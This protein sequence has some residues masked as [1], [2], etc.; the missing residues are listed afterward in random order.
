MEYVRRYSLLF[1]L[2]FFVSQSGLAVTQKTAKKQSATYS[3][4]TF[5]KDASVLDAKRDFG[6]KGDG[7]ADDT[8]AL[9]RGID[10]SC[11]VER[12]TSAVFYIPK[13]I[14]RVSHTLVVN[15]PTGPWIY[16]ESRDGV[17]IRL[18]DGVK[19]CNS[20]IRTHPR[21]TGPTSADWFFR[22]LH[23]FTVDV[24]KNPETDGIRWCSTNTGIIRN[25]RV[26]GHG[27]IGINNGFIDQS[28][29]NLIQDVI[30]EGFETGIQEAWNW[31]ATL[32]RI[33]IRNCRKQGV[34]VNAATVAIEDLVVE[35]TP[36]GLFC[37]YPNDWTWWGGVVA[38][39]GGRFSGG[40]PKGPAIHNRSILYAR[41]VKSEGV[42]MTIQSETPGGNS[43]GL[44]VSEY[45]SHDTKKLFDV[46]PDSTYLPIKREPLMIWETNPNN[47]V[48]ANDFG[49]TS[50]DSKDDTA[51]IQKAIDTAAKS[52]KTTVYL[53]GVSG[54]GWYNVD[55]EVLIHG[56]VR[57]VIGLGFGRML[58]SEK[59][60]FVITDKSAPIIKFQNLYAF[61]GSRV[62]VENRSA[63][64]TL[65]VES[66]DLKII[67]TG[68]GD[69]FATDCSSIIEITK[70]G[71][72]FWA[73]Q[74]NPEG[75]S[76]IG[77]VQNAGA[78]AWILGMKCEGKGVRALTSNGGRTEIFGIFNFEAGGYDSKDLRPLF[79]VKDAQFLLMGMRDMVFG[80]SLAPIKVRETRGNETRT[81]G[82]DKE[83]GWIGWSIYDGWS[84]SSR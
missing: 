16:G 65:I 57:H 66:C 3:R 12:Q 18:D 33:T 15:S 49:A 27:K 21:E 19:D 46:T 7:V 63:K 34:Y 80:G 50:N 11:G 31:G 17:I 5:P 14:Y 61:G 41:N 40:D 73:R 55:G 6:A 23:N 75:E 82:I 67:G 43:T 45:I 35:K 56:S 26:M 83:P 52:G 71:Q 69:I 68:A 62:G 51:A 4:V 29:P 20:V 10:A 79:V 37:D 9:Q 70:P 1:I 8:D 54:S 76:D 81:L 30:I 24:G 39:T 48:C 44:N 22:T 2:L 72:K 25:V 64:R 84:P 47:W 74:L 42:K 13:G 53:R 58:G 28:S 38:L 59:G 60:R 32:S 36:L 78:D 77:L